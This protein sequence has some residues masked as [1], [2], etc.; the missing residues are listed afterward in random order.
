MFDISKKAPLVTIL[1]MLFFL[2]N[3]EIS[4]SEI[5]NNIYIDRKKVFEETDKDWFFAANFFNSLHSTTKEYI[6]NDE[7]LFQIGDEINEENFLETERNLIATGLFTNVKIEIE[8]VNSRLFDIYVETKDR[9]SLF[10]SILVGANGGEWRLGGRIKEYNLLGRGITLNIDGMYTHNPDTTGWI[11]TLEIEKNRIFRTEFN[12]KMQLFN[13]FL[14]NGQ[15]IS[16]EKP[17][18]TLKTPDSYGISFSNLIGEDYFVNKSNAIF[19]D[20]TNLANFPQIPEMEFIHSSEQ[21][22]KLWYARSWF[23]DDRVFIS[24]LLEWQ[25][26]KREEPIF[27]RAYDNQSKFLL[28]F[29]SIS[30]NFQNVKNINSY[31]YEDLVVGGWGSVT[32]GAIFPSNQNGEKAFFYIGGQIEKSHYSKNLYLFGQLSASSIF[33]DDFAKYTYQEFLGLAFVR[34]SEKFSIAARIKEQAAWNYPRMRQLI[35]DDMHGVR[36]Y[37]L[38]K[39]AGDNRLIGNFEL[40]YFPDLRI[41]VMNISGVAFFDIGSVWQQR[42]ENALLNS[43]FYSSVGLGLRGHFTK[44]DNPDHTIRIDIPYN[45]HTKKFGISL[46]VYQYFSAF[47]NHKFH[48]PVIYSNEFNIE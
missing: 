45:L 30:Q 3:G 43:K 1:F 27:A 44:S 41:F 26:A 29:S 37:N 15:N 22:A 25:Q 12:T 8:E 39:L 18:R 9:W 38:Q 10:P 16:L 34:L 42:T 35:L 23:S 2:L 48:L 47:S 36:G 5:I 31:S 33:S 20:S 6:I 14:R 11:G 21:N 40:R 46:G 19:T 4:A 28:E 13:S 24:G 32:L 17:F 7:L